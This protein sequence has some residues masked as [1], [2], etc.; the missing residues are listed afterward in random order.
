MNQFFQ[1]L[2]NFFQGSRP[3]QVVMPWERALRVRL[4]KRTI[5]WEPGFHW[6]IPFVD[7]VRIVNTRLRI[8]SVPCITV[9]T[10]DGKTV[11]VAGC[12]GFRIFDPFQTLL[13][14]QHPEDAASALAQAAVAKYIASR[15]VAELSMEQMEQTA[16]DALTTSSMAG[17]AFEFVRVV[18]FAVV[19]TFRLLQEVWRP[20][21]GFSN[22]DP[23]K[24]R[25]A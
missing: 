11:T 17:L 8:A 9:T 7:E 19:R 14:I 3:W 16:L 2:A 10:T 20:N 5:L 21:T 6:R 22:L 25:P 12:V 24:V 18:D 4:G 1:W 23:P 15:R 13:T